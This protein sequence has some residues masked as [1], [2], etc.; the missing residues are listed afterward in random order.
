VQGT[1]LVFDSS[2][3]TIFLHYNLI[4]KHS[5][6]CQ[7]MDYYGI[8]CMGWALRCVLC[9]SDNVPDIPK[10]AFQKYWTHGTVSISFC[11]SVVQCPS[12]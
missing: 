9:Q 11:V 4:A 7:G 8:S 2:Y 10:S 5:H 1:V 3:P 6:Q 12:E